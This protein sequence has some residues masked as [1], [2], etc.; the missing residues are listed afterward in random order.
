MD[1]NVEK[2]SPASPSVSYSSSPR[3]HRTYSSSR[4]SSSIRQTHA[5]IPHTDAL[6]TSITALEGLLNHHASQLQQLADPVEA[7]NEWI[8]RD[9]IVVARMSADEDKSMGDKEENERK[10]ASP[11]KGKFKAQR[12]VS[13]EGT[14]EENEDGPGT[15]RRVQEAKERIQ[16]M[17]QWRKELKRSVCCQ[18][19]E[20]WQVEQA[21]G[22]KRSGSIG[23]GEGREVGVKESTVGRK[24][25][26]ERSVQAFLSSIRTTSSLV[27]QLVRGTNT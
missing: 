6:P 19:E 10:N 12:V 5:T 15:N 16:S 1:R 24:W 7:V 20:Y 4:R 18:R 3:T 21:M 23:R 17:Q 27:P 13:F 26:V 11:M 14:H 9:Q 2:D 22:R 25:D 8:D